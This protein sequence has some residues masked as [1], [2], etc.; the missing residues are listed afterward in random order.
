MIHDNKNTAIATK[1]GSQGRV[2]DGSVTISC[3]SVV[4]SIF[5]D[6]K[7]RFLKLKKVKMR[8]SPSTRDGTG[9]SWLRSLRDSS[10]R[11]P[12]LSLLR[13]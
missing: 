7:W 1:C 13:L 3:F 8:A 11:R 4:F 9:Y 6:I 2:L 10:F 5:L 12:F